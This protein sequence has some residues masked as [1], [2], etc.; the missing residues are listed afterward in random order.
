MAL[1]EVFLELCGIACAKDA[2]VEAH[3]EISSGSNKLNV[4]FARV[5]HD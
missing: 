1:K 5:A 2:S 4:G 3:L